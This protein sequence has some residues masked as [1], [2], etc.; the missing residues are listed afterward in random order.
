MQGRFNV[1]GFALSEFMLEDMIVRRCVIAGI[2]DVDRVNEILKAH[3]AD[4]LGGEQSQ[5]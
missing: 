5:P 2:Y 1:T 3:G 4:P